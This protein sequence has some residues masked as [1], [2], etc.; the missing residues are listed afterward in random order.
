MNEY[1]FSVFVDHAPMS[2]D[3]ILDATD[4]LGNAGCTDASV[5]GH[6]QGLELLFAR[7]AE[8]L[9]AAIATAVKDV[10]A[11]GFRVSRV[12]MEREAIPA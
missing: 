11:A 10:E 3:E 5:R 9:Q 7:S 4:S 12:E 2:H 8:S 6:S 1:H